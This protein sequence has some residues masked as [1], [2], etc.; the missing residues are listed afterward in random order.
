MIPLPFFFHR[1]GR[2][3]SMN[4]EK[5]A[6][7]RRCRASSVGAVSENPLFQDESSDASISTPSAPSTPAPA[8]TSPADVRI[9]KKKVSLFGSYDSY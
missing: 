9:P 4:A 2:A 6:A 3:G 1:R 7:K 5:P 8:S